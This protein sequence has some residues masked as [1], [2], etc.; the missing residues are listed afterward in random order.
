MASNNRHA[1]YDNCKSI[2]IFYIVLLHLC[3]VDLIG[4]MNLDA[5]WSPSM[6]TLFQGYNMWHEKLSIPGFV[7]ISGFFGKGFLPAATTTTTV[8]QP[9]I[10][11]KKK[12]DHLRW[13]KT[14]SV[15][16]VGSGLLQ[17]SYFAIASLGSRLVTGQWIA[18][19][20]SFPLFERLETWYLIALALWRLS[21]PLIARLRYPIASSFL[22]ALIGLHAQM[23]G[24]M[25]TR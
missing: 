19:P 8:E 6:K 18:P 1:G 4:W 17:M 14:I 25:D 2:F 3:H 11:G 22:I 12:S 24:P 10:T 23:E 21:T 7:F 13:E 9:I 16:L 5:K 15:L 20:T